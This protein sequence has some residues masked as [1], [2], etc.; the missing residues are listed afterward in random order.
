VE[1]LREVVRAQNNLLKELEWLEGEVFNDADEDNE[2][3]ENLKE[4]PDCGSFKYEGHEKLCSLKH[5]IS[6]GE[7]AFEGKFKII[8]DKTVPEGQ[9]DFVDFKEQK[10]VGRITGLKK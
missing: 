3:K 2:K 7:E 9:I 8:E 10:I 5:L 6:V 4:C 1:R